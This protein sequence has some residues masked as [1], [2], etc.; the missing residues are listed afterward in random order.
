MTQWWWGESH[1]WPQ[2]WK[3]KE[4]SSWKKTDYYLWT[5]FHKSKDTQSRGHYL[6]RGLTHKDLSG[7]HT[8][9]WCTI[10][11]KK[12][13]FRC[14]KLC[15]RLNPCTFVL[16][17]SISAEFLKNMQMSV[18]R[19]GFLCT[20]RSWKQAIS[21]KGKKRNFTKHWRCSFMKSRN[22]KLSFLARCPLV[23]I[24]N[25]NKFYSVIN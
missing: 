10:K 25:R 24:I 2:D 12:V 23:L 18:N 16:Y 21:P 6:T 22:K 13:P 20:N 9:T 15:A 8:E 5:A 1:R 14:M 19:V 7:F 3:W 11:S 4:K 17:I